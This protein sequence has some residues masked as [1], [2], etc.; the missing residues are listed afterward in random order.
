MSRAATAQRQ[1]SDNAATVA[2]SAARQ[3]KSFSEACSVC[4]QKVDNN[5]KKTNAIL[6][7]WKNKH[8][9]S[10][11][12]SSSCCSCNGSRD[13]NVGRHCRTIW[14]LFG[15]I[16]LFHWATA[17]CILLSARFS[18][19]RC[20]TL[21]FIVVICR[22]ARARYV[23]YGSKLPTG[24]GALGSLG[25]SAAAAAMLTDAATR[26]AELSWALT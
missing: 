5:K 7:H 16:S 10:N 13:G 26:A 6:R 25:C 9:T 14:L 20:R 15:S 18:V 8:K 17:G 11:N 3:N 1:R 2:T 19:I 12:S 21:L 4:K 22:G 23:N 24:C